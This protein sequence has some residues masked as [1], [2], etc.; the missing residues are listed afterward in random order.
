MTT[1]A[2]CNNMRM[3]HAVMGC[4]VTAEDLTENALD[5]KLIMGT[6]T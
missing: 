1:Q 2:Y 4:V 6:L 5:H 3:V